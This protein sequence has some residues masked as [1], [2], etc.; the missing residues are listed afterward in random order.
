MHPQE[1]TVIISIS[2]IDK[3]G[4]KLHNHPLIKDVCTLHFADVINQGLD[5][6]EMPIS[7]S[8]ALKIREFADKWWNN[9]D[10]FI[11]HCEAGQCRSAG[12]MVALCRAHNVSDEWIWTSRLYKPNIKVIQEVLRAY[13]M[14]YSD[15]TYTAVWNEILKQ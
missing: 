6:M 14:Y 5:P 1:S 7:A 9:V 2:D 3:A 15:E 11:V 4:A 8:D 12:C 13:E 10:H